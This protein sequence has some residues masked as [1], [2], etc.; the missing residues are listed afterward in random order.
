AC[1]GRSH[2]GGAI[3][4]GTHQRIRAAQGK[5]VGH[6]QRK[7]LQGTSSEDVNESF[8]H[9]RST[10]IARCH[11]RVGGSGL[12]SFSEWAVEIQNARLGGFYKREPVEGEGV[13]ILFYYMN[14]SFYHFCTGM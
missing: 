11:R 14:P 7:R 1:A 12:S 5:A 8:P 6:G 13:V 9:Q 4:G 10:Q 2:V 3:P